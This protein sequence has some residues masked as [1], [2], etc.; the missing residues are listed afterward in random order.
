MTVFGKESNAIF[1]IS[2]IQNMPAWSGPLRFKR[3]RRAF[4]KINFSLIPPALSAFGRR[5][6][7]LTPP[8]G[9]SEHLNL[10]TCSESL[11]T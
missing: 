10:G 7:K 8:E 11:P 9:D 5:K 3:W 2:H 4:W 6:E 1:V